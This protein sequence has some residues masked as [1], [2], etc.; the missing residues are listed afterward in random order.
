MSALS[1]SD[2]EIQALWHLAE[3]CTDCYCFLSVLKEVSDWNIRKQTRSGKQ[4]SVLVRGGCRFES[5]SCTQRWGRNVGKVQVQL[6]TAWSL[7]STPALNK[8]SCIYY[9]YHK[10][11]NSVKS[12]PK[13]PL[14]IDPSCEESTRSIH[15]PLLAQ[16]QSCFRGNFANPATVTL[17]WAGEAIGANSLLR[18]KRNSPRIL[19]LDPPN[20]H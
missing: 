7:G 19:L 13:H 1:H 4:G 3:A 14:F 10:L 9:S 11:T 12:K 16:P 2:D 6:Q 5:L 17:I 18:E 15:F 20:G 8:C